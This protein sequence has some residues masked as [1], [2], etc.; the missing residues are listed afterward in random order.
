MTTEAD[1]ESHGAAGAAA[2][3]GVLGR[4]SIYTIGTAAPILA[5]IAVVPVVT[6]MLGKPG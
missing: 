5:N 2:S 6:R 3:K 1:S 4:G